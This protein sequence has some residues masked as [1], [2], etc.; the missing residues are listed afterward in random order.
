MPLVRT[1][2]TA[3]TK[4]YE[5]MPLLD[6]GDAA[7][8]V[9]QACINK[10]TRVA[11]RLGTSVALLHAVAPRVTQI[12][13]NTTFRMFPDSSAAKGIKGEKSAKPGLSAEA[14]AMAE[15]MR[16]IHF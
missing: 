15:M 8:M 16:G 13:M 9:V 10:P 14:T 3:P 12:M 11:T 7:D 5:N 4:I 2:M 6:P 1:P